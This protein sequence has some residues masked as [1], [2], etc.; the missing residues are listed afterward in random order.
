[1]K[2]MIFR[3]GAGLLAATLLFWLAGC[4][5]Q[6]AGTSTRAPDPTTA[7]VPTA[8]PLPTVAL[9]NEPTSAA[10]AEPTRVS[11]QTELPEGIYTNP[12][13]DQDFPRPGRDPRGRM[14][15]CLRYQQRQYQRPGSPL[16]DLVEWQ[17]IR[18]A[19]PRLPEWSV[20]EFGWTWAPDVTEGPDG[21]GYLMYF[22]TRFA[23]GQ[24]GGVQCIGVA[25]GEAPEGPFEPRGDGPIVCQTG[26]GGSIDPATFI[27][28]DGQRYLLWKNDGNAIGGRTFLYIQLLA[29]DGLSLTGEPTPLLEADQRWEGALIEGPTLYYRDGRFTLFYSA[30]DYASQRYAVG[31]A[32]SNSLLGPY[33]KPE[34]PLLQTRIPEGRVGPGGQDV[35]TLADGSTWLVFH[36]W[37]AGG[38]RNMNLEEL[39]WEDGNQ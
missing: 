18:D 9:T 29:Q 34:E 10:P 8:L 38:Y 15:L 30:N 21:Q 28:Q 12:V 3:Q 7:Y 6:A 25:R 20:P 22:T 24:T 37:T 36:A 2:M 35:V 33:T 31:Y 26:Q 16:R 4:A 32:Q 1:M 27:D 13:F 5:D 11:T 19:L 17:F 14:V 23:V 39:K